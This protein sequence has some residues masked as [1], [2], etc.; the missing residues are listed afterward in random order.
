MEET[1]AIRSVHAH[2]ASKGTSEEQEGARAGAGARN[3]SLGS[4]TT[5]A[6]FA[7]PTRC[8]RIVYVI[9][10]SASMG[11]GGLFELACRELISSLERLPAA[12]RFQV[13]AYN[14]QA[15][16]LRIRGSSEFQAATA[17]SLVA[18]RELLSQ[19]ETEG[20]TDHLAAI[21]RALLLQP[22]VIYLV[23]DAAELGAREIH[24][25]QALNRKGTIINTIELR[26]SM[27]ASGKSSLEILAGSNHGLYRSVSSGF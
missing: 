27:A 22:D 5:T 24:A 12:A 25:I 20:G 19:M 23:T 18:V 14:R 4:G 10:R 17:A 1:A 16:V 26:R 8:R 2:A 7:I 3:G 21:K 15:E 11:P 9:D 13:I 6:F